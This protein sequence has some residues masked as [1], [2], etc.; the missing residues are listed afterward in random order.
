VKYSSQE[1]AVK[2]AIAADRLRTAV[3]QI[4]PSVFTLGSRRAAKAGHIVMGRVCA[5]G[6]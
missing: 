2:A 3:I 4:S 5:L 1:A 6:E